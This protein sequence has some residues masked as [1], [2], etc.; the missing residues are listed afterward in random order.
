MASSNLAHWRYYSPVSAQ[1]PDAIEM[2]EN[3]AYGMLAPV[4]QQIIENPL[5]IVTAQNL[6]HLL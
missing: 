1:Q 6:R 5:Y 4:R 3:D 2:K